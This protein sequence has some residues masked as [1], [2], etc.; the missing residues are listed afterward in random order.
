MTQTRKAEMSQYFK[1]MVSAVRNNKSIVI[2]EKTTWLYFLG[3]P[4]V[5]DFT[6]ISTPKFYKDE[7]CNFKDTGLFGIDIRLLIGESV[8]FYLAHLITDNTVLALFIT[9]IYEV[10]VRSIRQS[11]GEDNISEKTMIDSDFLK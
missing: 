4:P 3:I 1:N 11:V 5:E 8:M 6:T 9:F 2:P 10:I 7:G